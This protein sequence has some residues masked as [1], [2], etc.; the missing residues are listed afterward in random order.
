MG[1]GDKAEELKG[2]VKAAVGDATDDR[3]LEAEGKAEEFSGKAKQE[4][5]SVVDALR[6]AGTATKGDSDVDRDRAV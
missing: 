1:I 4:T 5:E 2:K 6:D 3:S